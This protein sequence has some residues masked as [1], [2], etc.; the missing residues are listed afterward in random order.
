MKKYTKI[1]AVAI[2]AIMTI[3]SISFV[4][5]NKE[6]NDDVSR[7]HSGSMEKTDAVSPRNANNP[8][9][10][11]GAL[12]NIMMD[13][14][15]GK[16]QSYYM[17]NGSW[18]IAAS[19]SIATV[20]LADHGFYVPGYNLNFITSLFADSASYYTDYAVALGA[21]NYEEENII[22]IINIT[23][24]LFF[25]NEPYSQIKE[26]IVNE[27]ALVLSNQGL[28]NDEKFVILS[29]T[30]V[31]R[32]SLYYWLTYDGFDRGMSLSAKED[33]PP[34]NSNS[35]R[36]WR[37][38]LADVGGALAGVLT[39][40]STGATIGTAVGNPV[41]GAA[42]GAAVGAIGGA[43]KSSCDK[44]TEEANNNQPQQPQ[45]E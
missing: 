13:E 34:Q 40:A 7:N 30:S 38:A 15:R 4:S 20:I 2:A 36:G 39:G 27:E 33:N 24:E 42:V 8:Y 29:T 28:T 16:M 3:G 9:D 21:T 37:I 41:A 43:V 17:A 1:L 45:G 32:H 35:G 11:I 31:L 14:C 23:R 25:A 22:N 18:S 44:A 10:T 6:N 26:R 19:D 12:H 5:C